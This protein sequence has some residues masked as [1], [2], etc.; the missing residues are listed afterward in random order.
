VIKINKYISIVILL[1]LKGYKSTKILIYLFHKKPF[2]FGYDEYKWH[3]IKIKI[4]Q[5]KKEIEEKNAYALDERII[6]Y[7]WIINELENKKG[8]LL[9]AGSALNFPIF[10]QRLKKFRLYIQTL[11]PEKN[12]FNKKNVNY[13]YEDLRKNLF[14]ENFFN[15]I[16]CIST[17]EHVG[18]D[19]NKYNYYK[20]NE[21]QAIINKNNDYL[22][23]IKNFKRILKNNG[24]LLLTLPFGKRQIFNDLQQFDIQGV[25]KILN[26]FKPKK[27]EQKFF[28]YKKFGWYE[29]LEKDC[30]NITFRRLNEKNPFDKAAS[31]RS[32]IF[33]KLTK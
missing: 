3:R 17:L 15:Y 23:V 4:N 9:D 33:I 16:T 2:A 32:V 20:K 13:V 22:K 21:R 29:C 11:Y 30:L 28:I 5:K 6:E 8:T 24:E 1:F 7:K 19:N 31:A 14:V 25:R 26:T 10:I 12:T 27:Y 18:M